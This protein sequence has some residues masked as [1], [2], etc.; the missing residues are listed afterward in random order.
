MSI[1]TKFFALAGILLA[2]FG[3]VVGV[4]ALLQADT[5]DNLEDI[6]VFHQPLSRLLSDVDLVTFEYEL[7]VERLRR[8]P[9][10]PA[11][12]LKQ[13]AANIEDIAARLRRDFDGIHNDLEGAVAHN[14]DDP[15][16]LLGLA[17]IQGA[18]KYLYRQVD[19]FL[20]VGKTVTDAVLAGQLEEAHAQALNF[21][22][23]EE[24]FGPDLAEVRENLVA[25]T[26]KAVAGIYAN[27]RLHTWLSFALFLVAS[28]IGLGISGVGSGQVVAALRKLLASTKA[29]EEGR[30]DVTV[31]VLTR[32]EVGQLA[33]AFNRMVAELR[34]RER[35]K[36]TF[37]KFID[38]RIVTRLIG[39]ADGTAEPAER[40][41]VTIF[42]SDI[43]GFSSISEQLTAASM[44]NL[45]NNYFSEVAEEIRRHNGIID[46]Y[47]GDSVMAFW[48]APFSPGDQHALDGC[49]AALAQLQ[50]VEA[51]RQR[52][53]EITGLRRNVPELVVRMG[54][55]TGEVVVGAIGSPNA[56]SYTV[57]GDT[58][59]LA[60][61]LEGVNK[62]YGT[63]IIV[64]EDTYRFAR[65]AVEARE[66]DV[67][68]V[69]GKSEPIRI[70][71]LLAPTGGLDPLRAELRE[72]FAQ[73][74]EAYRRQD[75]DAAAAR[76][77]AC[78][79]LAPE[80]GPSAVYLERVA[81]LRESP[82]PAGWDG[83]W[84]LRAK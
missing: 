55:A 79:R 7:L 56:R 82:P 37:G 44:V 8:Q 23:Y 75:W 50:A 4:L 73:G 71:E 53:P 48:C 72:S 22:R 69:A 15:Q 59:N 36:D 30:I 24:T 26:D 25:L 28:G 5:A 6:V 18:M 70:Y 81:L 84:R 43:K 57:I 14:T 63:S 78:R 51:V 66:L 65:H 32:D 47:I 13:A 21:T 46:K 58:V 61:R 33:L 38:P 27:Q 64:A 20:A 62:V 19:P 76:F 52:L 68:T 17:R 42:F 3:V 35:I 54:I 80:D 41:V 16:D 10:R 40:K 34:E 67:V 83:V 60:S 31:P 74:L 29:M 11:A 77:E 1:R 45:L 49:L 12:E 9:D 39:T 2:L